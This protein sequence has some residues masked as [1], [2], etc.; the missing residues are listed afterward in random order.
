MHWVI[1]CWCTTLFFTVQQPLSVTLPAQKPLM[2]LRVAPNTQANPKIAFVEHSHLLAGFRTL[3]VSRKAN[4]TL[5]APGLC[6]RYP[7]HTEV[8]AFLELFAEEFGVRNLVHFN[9]RVVEVRPLSGGALTRPLVS[10]LQVHW[11]GGGSEAVP[12]VGNAQLQV[13]CGAAKRRG[14]ACSPGCASAGHLSGCSCTHPVCPGRP[15]HGLQSSVPL[16]PH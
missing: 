14:P 16:L 15:L 5:H 7:H 3:F 6:C 8:Q 9:T 10:W 4:S 1:H 12:G 11:L 2:L 13:A